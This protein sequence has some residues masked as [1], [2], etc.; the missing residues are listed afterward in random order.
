MINNLS[1][2]TLRRAFA[3]AFL[4]HVLLLT[5]FV[6]GLIYW[7]KRRVSP[8]PVGVAVAIAEPAPAR[9][10]TD[11]PAVLARA[12][13]EIPSESR[14][15]P[16]PVVPEAR[17]ATIPEP[18]VKAPEPAALW[19][20]PPV[21]SSMAGIVP[22]DVPG[23]S[24][25]GSALSAGSVTA[26]TADSDSADH[27]KGGRPVA[28]SDIM[29]HYPYGARVRGEAGRV[30][31]QVRVSSKGVVEYAEVLVSSGYPALDESA[32]AATKKVRFKPAEEDGK[33]VAYNMSLQFEFRL[34]DRQE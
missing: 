17:S 1:S 25:A 20:V 12:L 3:F 10:A 21:L 27:R 2:P 28:L 11:E 13:A 22:V 34:E 30:K 8:V 18:M 7:P 33:P 26:G 23:L 4:L 32:V 16:A 9:V 6:L 31:V 29:P 24:S 15:V 19:T 14:D 5:V